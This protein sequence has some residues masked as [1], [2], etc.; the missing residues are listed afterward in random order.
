MLKSV[1]KTL[2]L[3]IVSVLKQITSNSA[4]NCAIM[5]GKNI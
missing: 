2:T 4:E 5:L 1:K 3:V